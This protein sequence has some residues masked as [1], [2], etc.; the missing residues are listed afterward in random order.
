MKGFPPK[1]GGEVVFWLRPASSGSS[2][3]SSGSSA[4]LEHLAGVCVCVC[5]CVR[6]LFYTST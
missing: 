4:R 5:V 3:A 1:A 6:P 2:W